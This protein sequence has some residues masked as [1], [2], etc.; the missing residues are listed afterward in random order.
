VRIPLTIFTV[1]M[2]ELRKKI[3]YVRNG[4]GSSKTDLPV[5]MFRFEVI[6]NKAVI[7]AANKEVFNRTE[8][9][10]SQPAEG[11]VDGAFG[12][13]GS[14][15]ESLIAKVE[16][17]QVTF[18]SDG[19]ENVEI[20]AGFLTVNFELYDSSSLRTI[21]EGVKEHLT[22]EGLTIPKEAIE[23]SL[24]CGKICTAASS[25]KLDL[26]HV[27]FRV[28]KVLSS[29]GRKIMIY[30]HSGI[31]KDVVLKIPSS[32]IGDVIGSVKNMAEIP[33]IQV[34][35]GKS[36]YYLKGNGN[37][38]TLG[39]RKVERSFPAIEAKMDN[40]ADAVDEV[41]VDKKVLETMLIGVSLGLPVD[42]VQVTVSLAGAGKESVLEVAATNTN[43]KRSHERSSCGRKVKDGATVAFPVSFKHILETL[44]VYKGDSVV[45]MFVLAGRN[46]LMIRDKTDTR[47]VLTCI[48]FR[49]QK[50]IE[51]ERKE[52][53]AAAPKPA[54]EKQVATDLPSNEDVAAVLED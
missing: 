11:S 13:L 38:F 4:L 29:D 35:E 39:V 31:P 15:I 41:S 10:I 32:S 20:N 52:K 5:M 26:N 14:K 40:V 17:E 27:E 36:Y 34:V 30:S 6:G 46:L 21:A 8:M 37:Q 43:G 24:V 22:M 49:T 9:K 25:T 47:Q 19:T 44:S 23:E 53:E 16:A 50:A 54:A 18:S 28:G 45:D 42:D 48:P 12:V 51:E 33:E 7:F 2:A 3:N 1:E